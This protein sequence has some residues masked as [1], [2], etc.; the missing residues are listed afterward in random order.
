VLDT[1]GERYDK[2]GSVVVSN[3]RST[4]RKY[5]KRRTKRKTWRA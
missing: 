4:A 2:M 5:G 1:D 3:K